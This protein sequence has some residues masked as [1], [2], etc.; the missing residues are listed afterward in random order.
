MNR[1]FKKI[2]KDCIQKVIKELTN[3]LFFVIV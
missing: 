3:T 2:P 1:L